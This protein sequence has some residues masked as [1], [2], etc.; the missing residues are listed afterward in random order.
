MLHYYCPFHPTICR[1][2]WCHW[3][4]TSITR[5]HSSLKENERRKDKTKE[6]MP[7]YRKTISSLLSLQY[8]ELIIDLPHLL[9]VLVWPFLLVT[10]PITIPSKLLLCVDSTFNTYLFVRRLLCGQLTPLVPLALWQL[11]RLLLLLL[12]HHRVFYAPSLWP[13]DATCFWCIHEITWSVVQET[14][15]VHLVRF[16]FVDE[17]RMGSRW[18]C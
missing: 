13:A 4:S 18:R 16:P 6:R 5:T 8:F 1:M 11:P 15:W 10:Y 12:Q 17:S 3:T 9:A 14:T 7:T 2:A